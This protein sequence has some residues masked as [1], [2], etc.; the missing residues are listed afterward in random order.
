MAGLVYLNQVG[1]GEREEDSTSAVMFLG[2]LIG[3][4]LGFLSFGVSNDSDIF[5]SL[6]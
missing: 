4:G 1:C 6:L 5:L 2:P 3:F